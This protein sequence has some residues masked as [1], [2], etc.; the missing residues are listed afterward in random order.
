MIERPMVEGE[1]DDGPDEMEGK[2]WAWQNMNS[3][4]EQNK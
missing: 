1:V 3:V 2:S 4:V